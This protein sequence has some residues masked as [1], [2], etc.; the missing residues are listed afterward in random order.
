MTKAG[1]PSQ[2]SFLL[3]KVIKRYKLR[4][5]GIYEKRKF[6]SCTLK[7]HTELF[8]IIRN[9]G[10]LALKKLSA[11]MINFSDDYFPYKAKSQNKRKKGVLA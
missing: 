3:Y 9:S 4:F 1:F 10:H 11:S 6:L 8:F 2:I 7:I 5:Y